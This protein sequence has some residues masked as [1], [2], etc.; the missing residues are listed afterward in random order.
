MGERVKTITDCLIDFL[1]ALCWTGIYIVLIILSPILTP[2]QRLY[3]WARY[4]ETSSGRE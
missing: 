2:P 3:E 1:I 4:R